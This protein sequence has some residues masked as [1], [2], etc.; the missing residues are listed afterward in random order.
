MVD[1]QKLRFFY[2]ILLSH[3]ASITAEDVEKCKQMDLLEQLLQEMAGDFPL[4]TKIFVEERDLYM[5]H[6]LQSLIAR[7]TAEK[8]AVW[9]RTD[10]AWQPLNIVAVVSFHSNCESN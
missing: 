2:H 6:V 10:A 8:R 5:V 9:A 7:T 1:L 4:L 3:N